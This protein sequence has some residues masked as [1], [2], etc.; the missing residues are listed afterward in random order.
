MQ[1]NT[2]ARPDTKCAAFLVGPAGSG[3]TT[4]ARALS[5]AGVSLIET[6]NLLER[7]VS[8]QSD[9]GR[10][11]KPYK[12]AG[13]LVPSDLVKKVVLAE[14]RTFQTGLVLFDGFPRSMD[15]VTL[16]NELMKED[17]REICAVVVLTFSLESS[18]KR[19]SGRRICSQCGTLYNIYPNPPAREEVCDKC[20]GKLTQ[21]GDDREEL[22]RH[23]FATFQRETVPVI[24]Y[25]NRECPS[26]VSEI[27]AEAPPAEVLAHVRTRLKL[28]CK[29]S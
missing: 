13:E 14:L 16:L 26:L 29:G 17:C 7:E 6:G 23:R 28:Q 18:I 4:L 9:L 25:F 24:E 10:Q 19:L 12:T 11:I 27:S 3:K 22:V 21:R 8:R 1:P 15:Q 5:G 2:N 20:G